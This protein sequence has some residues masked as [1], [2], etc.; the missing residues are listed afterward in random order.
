MNTDN[1]HNH[2]VLN[3]TSCVDGKRYCH[4]KKDLYNLHI[5]SDDLCRQYGSVIEE[6]AYQSKTRQQYYYEKLLESLV[7]N[8]INEAVKVSTTRTNFFNQLQFE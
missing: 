6:K 4:T 5:V 1:I 7:K 2:F 8:D 3:A